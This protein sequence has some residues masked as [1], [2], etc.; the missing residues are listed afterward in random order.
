[1]TLRRDDG[2]IVCDSVEVADTYLR[3]LRGLVGRRRLESGRGMVIRPAGSIHT[4]FM[5]FPID[6]VFLD[7]NQQVI[8]VA[9]NLAPF[10]AAACRG[11]REVVELAAGECERRELRVGDR[12]AWAALSEVDDR[13]IEHAQQ[14][15][16]VTAQVLVASADQ[17]FVKL[18]RYLLGERR[19]GVSEI[20]GPAALMTA[21]DSTPSDAVL[22]DAGTSLGEGLRTANAVRARRPELP[23]VITAEKGAERSPAALRVYD[24]WDE[25]DDL[26]EAV[27]AALGLPPT[28]GV[29]GS[30]TTEVEG[31]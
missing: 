29:G 10:K 2:R 15:Q 9:P 20:V 1:L 13:R 18:T 23:V 12:V 24:K 7:H 22:L 27:A 14:P 5:R 4:Q 3:K 31:R 11:A 8:H 26:V 16:H 17:R 6:A 19:I 25:T 28:V 30:S 21:L